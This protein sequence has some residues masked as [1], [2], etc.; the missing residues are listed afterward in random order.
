MAPMVVMAKVPRC[1]RTSNGWGSRSL[2]QPMPL[3]P[4]NS[5]MSFSKRVLNGAFSMEWIWRWKPASRSSMTMPAR[6]VPRCE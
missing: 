2:M 6:R 5:S 1:E 3:V 4:W